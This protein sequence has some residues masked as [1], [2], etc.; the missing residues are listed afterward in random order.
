MEPEPVLGRDLGHPGPATLG[1]V[2]GQS[3]GQG[4]TGQ[5]LSGVGT[6]RASAPMTDK[7][8]RIDE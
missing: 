6:M 4:V 3:G 2:R 5:A 1:G 7:A 8:L